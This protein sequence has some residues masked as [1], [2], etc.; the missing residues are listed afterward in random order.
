MRQR[1]AAVIGN[2]KVKGS[3]SQTCWPQDGFT[4]FLKISKASKK[5]LVMWVISINIYHIKI[6]TESFKTQEYSSTHSI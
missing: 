2:D 4:T 5:V 3:S 1:W 6:K